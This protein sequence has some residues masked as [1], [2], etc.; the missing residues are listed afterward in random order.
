MLIVWLQ[1]LDLDNS[2]ASLDAFDKESVVF[3]ALGLSSFSQCCLFDDIVAFS[4]CPIEAE[5]IYRVK[6]VTLVIISH[7]M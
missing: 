3:L 2:L 1:D 7:H 6:Q 5:S 4:N